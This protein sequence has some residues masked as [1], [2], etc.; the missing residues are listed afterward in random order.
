MALN[1][2]DVVATL[3]SKFISLKEKKLFGL[4]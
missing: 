2:I 4:I 3:M 1:L